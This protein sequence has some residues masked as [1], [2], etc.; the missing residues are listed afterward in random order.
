MLVGSTIVF[1]D[2]RSNLVDKDDAAVQ[3]RLRYL[4][5]LGDEVGA[6]VV[7]HMAVAGQPRPRVSNN[8]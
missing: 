2:G 5:E 6:P 3:E 1:P 7:D 8:P 4:G